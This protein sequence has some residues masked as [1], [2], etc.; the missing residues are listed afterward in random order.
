MDDKTPAHDDLGATE[1]EIITTR[2]GK[3]EALRALGVDPF[4]NGTAPSHLA[5][6]LHARYGAAPAEEIARGIA[7]LISPEASYV[8]GATLVADGGLCM[9]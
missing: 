3:A 9:Y 8:D 1:R 5:A 6:D 2:L 4:G 7:F